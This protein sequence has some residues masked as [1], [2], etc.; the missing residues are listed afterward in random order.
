M[1]DP[2]LL[3]AAIGHVVVCA[4]ICALLMLLVG[5]RDE[6]C[7]LAKAAL[8]AHAQLF[9]SPLPTEE[10]WPSESDLTLP[11]EPALVS[12]FQRPPPSFA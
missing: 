10:T 12:L 5:Y 2:G 11:D 3:F 7:E 1:H 4:C 8:Q 6:I 9:S